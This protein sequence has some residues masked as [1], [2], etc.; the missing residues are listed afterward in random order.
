MVLITFGGNHKRLIAHKLV[1][2]WLVLYRKSRW[3]IVQPRLVIAL[4]Q[5]VSKARLE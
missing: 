5:I 4:M 3:S 2:I 1:I